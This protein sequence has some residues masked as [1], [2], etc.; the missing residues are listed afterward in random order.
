MTIYDL[1]IV[2]EQGYRKYKESVR[3]H[4]DLLNAPWFHRKDGKPWLYSQFIKESNENSALSEEEQTT[5][6]I[7]KGSKLAA[8]SDFYKNK[9]RQ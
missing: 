6:I 8:K 5:R 7:E 3:R 4:V 1:D 9:M 2:L